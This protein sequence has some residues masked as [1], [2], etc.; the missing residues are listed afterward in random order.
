MLSFACSAESSHDLS[1]RHIKCER[2]EQCPYIKAVHSEG[3]HVLPERLRRP[4]ELASNEHDAEAQVADDSHACR[5]SLTFSN[6]PTKYI[7]SLVDAP[8]R[9][10]LSV[11]L[12]SSEPREVARVKNQ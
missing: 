9:V 1:D 8:G 5:R 7:C 12:P 4:H 11:L 6:P 10:L 2:L 3:T